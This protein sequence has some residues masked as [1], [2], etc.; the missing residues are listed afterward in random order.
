MC[1]ENMENSCCCCFGPQGPQGVPG[2]QGPQGI[3]G[4]AGPQGLTGP[5]GLTGPMG[6]SGKDGATGSPGAPGA[7]GP[8][9]ATGATGPQGPQGATGLD[10]AMG[11][12]G[13]EGPQGITGAQ[14]PQGL[15]GVPGKDCEKHDK[16]CPPA[17]FDVY[18][19]QPQTLT[20][21]PAI[22]SSVKME[23]QNA[24]STGDFDL[25]MVNVDGTIKFLKH[26]VYYISLQV[27]AKLTPPFPT[28]VPS[29]VVALNRNGSLVKGSVCSGFN[30]SPNDN[31]IEGSSDV[32][33][34]VFAGDILSMANYT[35]S[36]IDISPII[37]GS[38]I[39]GT[40]ASLTCHS[41]VFLP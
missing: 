11:P 5:T 29:W 33:I 22:G 25:S 7:Q 41:L 17:Y 40:A 28:P 31:A 2:L 36:S 13:P 9:G 35:T 3:Q 39:P 14:G 38:T 27:L 23:L 1:K 4:V 37:I 24:V 6:P 30:S 21:Y 16:C 12:A 32:E 34:E 20:T 8:V 18:T 10:G 26:G 19:H 15:Q